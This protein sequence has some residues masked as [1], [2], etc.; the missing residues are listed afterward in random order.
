M[1]DRFVVRLSGELDL[2]NAGDTARTMRAAVANVELPI[3]TDL[4]RIRYMD[5][6]ALRAVW[7]L[8]E[9][10]QERGGKLRVVAP[11]G[12]PARQLLDLVDAGQ[13]MVFVETVEAP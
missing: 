11:V 5:S 4:T 12:S 1:A 6:A 8:A 9:R 10:E 7:E 2:S 3:V 13:F